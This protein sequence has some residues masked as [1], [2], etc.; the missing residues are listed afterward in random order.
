[1]KKLSKSHENLMQNSFDMNLAQFCSSKNEE[2]NYVYKVN[3]LLYSM[4]Q[5]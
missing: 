2:N 4:V 5:N 1:M 3:L